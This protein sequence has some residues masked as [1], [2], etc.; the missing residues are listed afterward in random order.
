MGD[1]MWSFM[2]FVIGLVVLAC[3]GVVKGCNNDQ[4]S[5]N[6]AAY[7]YRYCLDKGHKPDECKRSGL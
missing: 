6:Q 2:A 3:L 1:E 4:A 5:T 7:N